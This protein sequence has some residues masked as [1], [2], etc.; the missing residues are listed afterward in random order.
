[1]PS[2]EPRRRGVHLGVAAMLGMLLAIPSR[3][4]D[5]APAFR[6]QVLNGSRETA[7]VFWLKSGTER[8]P[9]GSIPPGDGTNLTTLPGQRFAVVGRE[10]LPERVVTS[11]VPV[12]A[13]RYEPPDPDGIPPFYTQ[14]T[15]AGGFPIVASARVDPH[16]L[17]EAAYLVDLM[18]AR[19]PDLR[20]AMI[21]SGARLSILARDEFTTDQPEWR[22]LARSPVPEFPGIAP[23]DYWDA[24][25]R[26]MGGSETDPF[27]SCGE[28][29][30]L[31]YRG[32][33]Y[34][35]ENILIHEFAHSIHLRGMP[36]VDPGFDGRVR[37]A[38]D[39]AMAA[40]LWKGK[41]AAV[42]H[43]EYF[44]EGVQSWF[45]D[46]REN[47]HDHNHVNTRAE[48]LDY[49]PGLA[50]LC[51]EVFG[52]TVLKYTRP[53]T[54]LTG[55]LAGYDPAAAPEFVWPGRLQEA[56][57]RIRAA[58]QLRDRAARDPDGRETRDLAGW[59]V[60]V[61]RRLL[62][63]DERP[64]T[65]RALELMQA[66]LE[67]IAR[68]V[69]AHAVAALRTVPLYVSPPYEG[70][71]A[72]AEYHPDRSWLA[73]NRRD[74]GMARAVEFTNTRIFEAEC[75]R[76]PV[77]VLHELAHA[78]HDRVL[79]NDHP[80]IRAA[81]EKARASGRYDRV[82]RQDS[83]GRRRP[84]KAYAL[85]NPQEYFAET[86][87]AYFAENDFFPFDRSELERH[88]PEMFI[89]LGTLWNHP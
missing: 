73:A 10:G 66:Q 7:D 22:W 38:Y 60:H 83:E 79:G 44:A 88:D 48:L 70:F 40:G 49:D 43:H 16:A 35:T 47:D 57:E 33:P 18:L 3:A 31:G 61:S 20:N 24:R 19:R 28:E 77:L 78:Y 51:R 55:H 63:D 21:R 2:A 53:A 5:P 84:D 11:E 9:K 69:P 32:D 68:L 15:T 56:R 52:D 87:E 89:L 58:A 17:G 27:C 36:N 76:M 29:N 64:A 1:M 37:A 34:A 23:R 82:E 74:P 25:A 12:Q 80:G 45:D 71:G 6:L 50:A 46:N 4:Q 72:K 39:A 13:V 14:R 59:Q 65:E 85:T 42:N 67:R 26:G 41:Y 86:T 30:L 54:R 62:L 8:V 81:Y 75:R